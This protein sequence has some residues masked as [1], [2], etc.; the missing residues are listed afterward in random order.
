MTR[1]TLEVGRK[2][3]LLLPELSF[4]ACEETRDVC[5]P[6]VFPQGSLTAVH[7]AHE[8]SLSLLID[9]GVKSPFNVTLGRERHTHSVLSLRGEIPTDP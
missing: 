8:V 7:T 3:P 5:L 2:E 6:T 1:M 4:Q 9:R